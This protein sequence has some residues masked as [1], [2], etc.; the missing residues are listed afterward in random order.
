M[1]ILFYRYNSICEP[2]FITLFK[3][4]GI[5]VI[6][7]TTE[8]TDKTAS[9][10]D[11]VHR[12][13][14]T[15]SK[16]NFLFVMSINFFPALSSVCNIFKIPYVSIVVDCPVWELYSDEIKNPINRIFIFDKYQ[17]NIF[18]PMNKQGVF[19]LPLCTDN[20][21]FSKVIN[22]ANTDMKKKYSCDISFIGSLYSEKCLYNISKNISSYN[23]GYIDAI[24]KIYTGLFG[25]NNISEC[26]SD[27]VVNNILSELDI[28]DFSAGTNIDFKEYIAD[29]LIGT[30]IS[31]T[32]RILVLKELS[33][34]YGFNI[35]LYTGSDTPMLPKVKNRGLAKSLTEMPLIFNQSRINL[36]ITSKSIKTGISQRVFDVLACRGFLISNYQEELFEYFTP[37]EDLEIFSS[38]EELNAKIKYYLTH[39]EE[40]TAIADHGYNTILKYHSV[41]MRVK[42]ILNHI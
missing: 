5:T 1:N 39:E 7:D 18:Y 40:R 42:D 20:I 9:A 30:K 33:E 13:S 34:T 32:D 19:H 26:L 3:A 36:N 16:N 15:L 28:P 35:D 2:A 41:E 6:E 29:T 11:L 31:E 25:I 4:I 21:T 10:S 14:N 24:I 12:V 27:D 22:S 17:Y 38:I 37:G 23:K 8:M